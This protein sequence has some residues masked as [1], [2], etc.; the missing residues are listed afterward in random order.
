MA[1]WLKT[2]YGNLVNVD[3]A[4]D[5][6]ITGNNEVKVLFSEDWQTT[7]ANFSDAESAEAY[8]ED[9]QQELNDL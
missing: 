6:V 3:L 2:E 9:L 5:I 1:T 8:L 7:L 4:T